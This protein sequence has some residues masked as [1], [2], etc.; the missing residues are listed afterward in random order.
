MGILLTV[1]A[2]NHETAPTSCLIQQLEALEANNC[3]QITYNGITSGFEGESWRHTTLRMAQ[4]DGEYSV[5]RGAHC[6]SYVLLREDALYSFWWTITRR[7][8]PEIRMRDM[9]STRGRVSQT[10][11]EARSRVGVHSSKLWSYTRNWAKS[12]GWVLFCEWALFCEIQYLVQICHPALHANIEFELEAIL[13]IQVGFQLNSDYC[14]G[15]KPDST[16]IK[17]I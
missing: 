17:T 5:A 15:C 12:R 2:F 6:I 14:T 7:F 11:C 3:T 13:A 1:S 9:H 16:N 10:P 8:L 4:C